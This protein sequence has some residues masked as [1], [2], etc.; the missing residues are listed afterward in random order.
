[1]KDLPEI[2]NDVHQYFEEVTKVRDHVLLQARTLNRHAAQAVRATHRNEDD[3]TCEHLENGKQILNELRNELAD[4]PDL[5]Y[6]GYTQDAIKE[7]VEAVITRALI[8]N[9]DLPKP[10]ELG[11]E[12]PTYMKGIAEVPGELRRRC[13]DILRQGYSNEAERLL[14]AMDEIYAILVTMDYPDAITY[15]LR[16]Q[17]DLVRGILERTRGDITLSLREEK[18]KKSIQS[19]ID[20]LPDLE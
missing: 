19:L 12:Y 11:V 20:K 16:R 5:Y 3:V 18:M 10:D 4:F 6:A 15:G 8:L 2:T 13:L 17:T 9:K 1:M 7:Y 14:T